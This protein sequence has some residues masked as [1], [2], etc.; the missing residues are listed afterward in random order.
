[1]ISGTISADDFLSAQRLHRQPMAR[2]QLV[3]LAALML[4]GLL[5]V[6]AG[7]FSLGIITFG[8]GAGGLVGELVL[9]R[10]LLTR[11]HLRIYHQQTSLRSSYTYSWDA[12]SISVVCDS[13][14][15][16]RS[17]SDYV[18]S[19]ENDQMFLLYHSDVMFEIFPKSWFLNWEQVKAFRELSSQVG[20]SCTQAQQNSGSY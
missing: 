15:A 5:I 6:R 10:L 4:I 14:Q 11:R 3:V 9:S 16:K 12:E 13:G 18:K 8:A 2:R 19:R 7:Y 20:G 17:W 1:M